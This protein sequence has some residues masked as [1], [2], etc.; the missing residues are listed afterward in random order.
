[1]NVF[2]KQIMIPALFAALTAV[3]GFIRIPVPPVPITFQTFFVYLAGSMLGRG[4]G[5]LSQVLFLIIGLSGVPVFSMGGGL[6]YVLKPSFGYLLGFPI[7]AFIIGV[8]VEKFNKTS[9]FWKLCVANSIGLFIILFI[10]VIYLYFN[11]NYIVHQEFSWAR[12][13]WVGVLVFLPGEVVKMILAVSL[14]IR[15]KPVI[16]FYDLNK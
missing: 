3:G 15:L 11:I 14:V 1:M 8:C 5:A 12:A 13:L 7:G 9:D 16:H 4:G 10:G 2:T 6:G